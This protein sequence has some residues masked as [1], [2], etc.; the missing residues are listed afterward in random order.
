MFVAAMEE[1][2]GQLAALQPP[3]PRDSKALP[4]HE[5]TDAGGHSQLLQRVLARAPSERLAAYVA[6]RL[7]LGSLQRGLPEQLDQNLRLLGVLAAEMRRF[8]AQLEAL[9]ESAAA[10]ALGDIEPSVQEDPLS[11]GVAAAA[12]DGA[13][14]MAGVLEGIAKET[15]L[16]VRAGEGYMPGKCGMCKR[17]A[18]TRRCKLPAQC[19]LSAQ[20]SAASCCALPPHLPSPSNCLLSVEPGLAAP[21]Q[22]CYPPRATPHVP[23]GVNR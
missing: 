20:T 8:V 9:A 4:K 21:A 15:T 13:L 17:A 23:A 19:Q 2:A 11:S 14:L 12:S 18:G 5:R 6:G 10:A 3:Q 22:V 16:I 7:P 1:L